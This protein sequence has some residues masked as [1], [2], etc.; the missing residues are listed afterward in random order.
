MVCNVHHGIQG[1]ETVRFIS[2]CNKQIC[3]LV[4]HFLKNSGDPPVESPPETPHIPRNASPF[5]FI[6]T[7]GTVLLHP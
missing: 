3:F 1:K 5:T 4:F 6:D 7:G 2:L